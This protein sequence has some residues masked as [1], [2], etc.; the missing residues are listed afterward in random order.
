ME[1]VSQEFSNFSLQE[2]ATSKAPARKMWG[3]KPC[4]ILVVPSEIIKNNLRYKVNSKNAKCRKFRPLYKSCC[5]C[6]YATSVDILYELRSHEVPFTRRTDLTTSVFVQYEIMLTL[7]ELKEISFHRCGAKSLM[8][9][10]K[11]DTTVYKAVDVNGTVFNKIRQ[12]S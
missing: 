11:P 7:F 1:D 10:N 4:Q 9:F 3:F 12:Y 6:Q 8:P 5:I 2:S